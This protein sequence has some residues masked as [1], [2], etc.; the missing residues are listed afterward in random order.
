MRPHFWASRG[1][2]SAGFGPVAQLARALH[3]QCRG[4][5]FESHQV[6]PSAELRASPRFYDLGDNPRSQALGAWHVEVFVPN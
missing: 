4:H 2:G 1:T 5:G 6:H 3:L